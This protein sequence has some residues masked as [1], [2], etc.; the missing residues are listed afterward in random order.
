MKTITITAYNRPDYLRQCVASLANCIGVENYKLIASCEPG[1]QEVV[2]IFNKIDWMEVEVRINSKKFGC[3]KNIM[4]SINNGFNSVDKLVVIEDDLIFSPDFLRYMEWG[5]D[6]YE[7]DKSVWAICASVQN[8][9]KK[10]MPNPGSLL[11][12]QWFAPWGWGMWKDR[13]EFFYSSQPHSKMSKSWDHHCNDARVQWGD[14]NEIVPLYSRAS[15]I[16]D[17][18]VHVR[19]NNSWLQ[20]YK[21]H[22][23]FLQDIYDGLYS[24]M[25]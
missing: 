8:I 6:N 21:K 3:N 23:H 22:E 11:R 10:E 20:K 17:T 14:A 4:E 19:P 18:G 15:H 13:F 5:L 24:E 9:Q 1:V 2:D 16:G 12:R 7:S 25:C